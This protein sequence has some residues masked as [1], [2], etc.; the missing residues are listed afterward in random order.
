[1][2]TLLSAFSGSGVKGTHFQTPD[3]YWDRILTRLPL[4]SI[5][6]PP[7]IL[8]PISG[9]WNDST[10]F[11]DE[12]LEEFYVQ[13]KG[14][15]KVIKWCHLHLSKMLPWSSGELVFGMSLWSLVKWNRLSSWVGTKR[16]FI[17]NFTNKWVPEKSD[18]LC[19]STATRLQCSESRQTWKHLDR[20]YFMKLLCLP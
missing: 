2:E 9:K 14:Q 7:Y 1:M 19:R 12:V 20:G 5:F 11:M 13:R 4:G 17:S 8:V 16:T 18:N 15:A 6:S 10:C 3:K